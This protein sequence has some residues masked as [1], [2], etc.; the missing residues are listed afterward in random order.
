MRITSAS[1]SPN[2]AASFA[3]RSAYSSAAC[4]SC[5]EHGPTIATKRRSRPCRASR[6]RG[7]PALDGLR[8]ARAAR[9]PS[10]SAR[11]VRGSG[12]PCFLRDK[13]KAPRGFGLSGLGSFGSA[14]AL[15]ARASTLGPEIGPAK[16]EAEVLRARR[17]HGRLS[18]PG[19]VGVNGAGAR[20]V[21]AARRARRRLAGSRER[22][23]GSRSSASAPARQE[24]LAPRAAP[25]E[26]LLGCAHVARGRAGEVDSYAWSRA[27]RRR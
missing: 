13:E 11:P 4:G 12:S 9:K 2:S 8:G 19:A 1:A 6:K 18:T 10:R 15:R 16:V 5:T 20:S 21:A 7:A 23:P 26:P 25:G 24:T 3:R 27:R 14:C 22:A 17:A